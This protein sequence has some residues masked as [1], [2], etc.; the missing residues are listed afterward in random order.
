MTMRFHDDLDIEQF[1][2]QLAIDP[3][4]LTRV[5]AQLARYYLALP[6]AREENQVS[7]LMAHPDN[8]TAVAVLA[9]QLGGEIL[10][11][12]GSEEGVRRAIQ[13]VYRSDKGVEQRPVR[14]VAWYGAP[15]TPVARM[16]RKVGHFLRLPVY[17]LQQ[18]AVSN[19]NGETPL[20][21]VEGMP[22]AQLPDLLAQA[23]GPLLLVRGA[24][25][26]PRRVLVALRGFASD[27]TLLDLLVPLARRNN[28]SLTVLMLATVHPINVARLL[29]HEGAMK[30]HATACLQRLQ[31]EG[32]QAQLRVQPGDAVT[33]IVNEINQQ[34][35][36]LLVL[37]AEG[38]GTFV[39]HL[40]T[41]LEQEQGSQNYS[42][43]IVK[44]PVPR[45]ENT[46]E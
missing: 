1:V 35:Y 23:S 41:M 31:Q 24:T 2:D 14:Q 21:V 8:H 12:G 36:D 20:L 28:V 7:V 33:Q 25:E 4:L 6:L 17:H 37:A 32:I 34:S 40:L 26:L 42:V 39:A 44:P 13:R 19:E 15:F 18:G 38:Q 27:A 3:E 11:L 9:R 29:C 30:A 10:P 16:A 46:H 43:L 22:A 5:S 45:H